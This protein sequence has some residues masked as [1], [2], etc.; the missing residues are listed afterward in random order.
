MIA[1][2]GRIE[3]QARHSPHLHIMLWLDRK[4]PRP[5]E[6]I[7]E[8]SQAAADFIELRA[9]AKL[10]GDHLMASEAIPKPQQMAPAP[11]IRHNSDAEMQAS[12]ISSV[13]KYSILAKKI[14][15]SGIDG[16]AS[17]KREP[18]L[19]LRVTNSHQCSSYCAKDG[20]KCKSSFPYY[21]Q[22]RASLAQANKNSE[23]SRFVS[24]APRSNTNI[25]CAHPMLPIALHANQQYSEM[26]SLLRAALCHMEL[27]LKSRSM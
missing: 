27:S 21:P 23:D 14:N 3:Q 24:L 1:R 9:A 8:Y 11:V 6:S 22:E 18:R 20:R 15:E 13:A 7:E 25:N 10:P 5:G 12:C 2:F 26:G 19:L 16:S 4:A 17:S